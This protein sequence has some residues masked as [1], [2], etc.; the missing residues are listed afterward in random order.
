[1]SLPQFFSTE[2]VWER[3]GPKRPNS[4]GRAR[5][6]YW[7]RQSR[8]PEPGQGQRPERTG[9]EGGEPWPTGAQVDPRTYAMAAGGRGPCCSCQGPATEAVP[10]TTGPGG[11]GGG[12]Q[13]SGGA[14][15]SG[16]RPANTG[17]QAAPRP[18]P[19]QRERRQ[20]VAQ[21]GSRRT[22]NGGVQQGSY[23]AGAQQ[24]NCRAPATPGGRAAEASGGTQQGPRRAAADPGGGTDN[25]GGTRQG[26]RRAATAH[27]GCADQTASG[28]DEDPH[29]GT[30]APRGKGS[31]KLAKKKREP[32][33]VR[34]SGP[35]LPE[36]RPERARD[37]RGAK[38]RRKEQTHGHPGGG[39]TIAPHSP[40]GSSGED[41]ND[42]AIVIV[43]HEGDGVEEN[44]HT[45]SAPS[46]TIRSA[47]APTDAGPVF[48]PPN[49][50]QTGWQIPKALSGATFQL[51]RE[52]GRY[53][54]FRLRPRGQETAEIVEISAQGTPPGPEG[55]RPA[56]GR[57]RSG[58]Q[59]PTNGLPER[60]S[61]NGGRTTGWRITPWE[62]AGASYAR[63]RSRPSATSSHPLPDANRQSS[64]D[65]TGGSSSMSRSASGSLQ[66]TAPPQDRS[67]S[68]GQGQAAQSG[69]RSPR[70]NHSS[71]P[72]DRPGKTTGS[73]MSSSSQMK[74]ATCG[75]QRNRPA[76]IPTEKMESDTPPWDP[77][78]PT[79]PPEVVELGS[80]LSPEPPPI[81]EP[82]R[83][84]QPSR[85]EVPPSNN[86]DADLGTAVAPAHQEGREEPGLAASGECGG[87]DA[88][89]GEAPMGPR[90]SSRSDA[91]PIRVARMPESEP[92]E[93]R[94]EVHLLR[95]G[96]GGAPG[97]AQDG[98]RRGNT[99][100]EG[101][102]KP[103]IRR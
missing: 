41:D 96:D 30:D 90:P 68:P 22:G 8:S 48:L 29:G 88:G 53:E 63:P 24:G 45:S 15:P 58:R 51:L 36:G 31:R 27:G 92:G 86:G 33:A 83:S 46:Q 54:D 61:K 72:S 94:L 26:P 4:G 91:G 101:T 66:T 40:A 25:T 60:S 71:C 39:T 70:K 7:S 81:Q 50:G 12:P 28:V 35:P 20:A 19:T 75:I 76:V 49:G 3:L 42:S 11:H 37:E 2:T 16:P 99:R 34:P 69:G 17:H 82:S 74:R 10:G 18:A 56:P 5:E 57:S 78:L 80:P 95:Q 100:P 98:G 79:P 38:S 1:M 64:T 14:E 13:P 23:Q 6:S 77:R 102:T 103:C 87:I 9:K 59:A 67:P 44:L 84:L 73:P 52:L 43:D 93:T 85:T 65:P 55:V 89:V 47:A 32:G 97:V 21:Q 62:G